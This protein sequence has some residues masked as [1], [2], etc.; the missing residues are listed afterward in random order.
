MKDKFI[1]V[2]VTDEDGNEAED[3]TLSK[4]GVDASFDVDLVDDYGLQDDGTGI[5]GDK[6]TVVYGATFGV[7]TNVSWYKD[8]KVVATNTVG[9]TVN[10]GLTRT[11]S[12]SKWGTGVYK[13]TITNTDG[14]VATTNEIEIT[15]KEDAAEILDFT[16]ENDYTDGLDIHYATTDKRAVATVTMSK[17]YAGTFSV[18]RATDTAFKSALAND[19]LKTS[20]AEP[21]DTAADAITYGID[22]YSV[23]TT[24]AATNYQVLNANSIGS[25]YGYI[26][27]DGTVTYKWVLDNTGVVRGAD[28]VVA[29]D[30]DSISSDKPGTGKANVSDSATAPYVEAPASIAVTKVAENVKPEITFFDEDDEVL[31]WFGYEEDSTSS[32]EP[33]GIAPS[34]KT[35]LATV[36]ASAAKVYAATN[37]TTDPDGDGVTQLLSGTTD[38]VAKGVWTVQKAAGDEAYF[39]ATVKF[40]K[41]IFGE[42]ALE[43]K[44]EAAP[45]AQ[46]AATDMSLL[47]SKD[48][49]SSAVVS[50]ANLRADGTVYIARGRFLGNGTA[51]APE[52]TRVV[53]YADIMKEFNPDD[54][55]TFVAKADVEAGAKS[56]TVEN[57][58][59]SFT[60]A[61]ATSIP[62]ATKYYVDEK[63]LDSVYASGTTYG[64]DDY[65]A[66]FVPDDTDN[67][68]QVSTNDTFSKDAYTLNA[69]NKEF[70]SL[71]VTQVPKTLSND[72]KVPG[73]I[74]G[75][76]A[77]KLLTIT[78]PKL[79]A[80]DQFGNAILRGRAAEDVDSVTAVDN[81]LTTHEAGSAKYAI[82]DG[83]QVTIYLVV[84]GDTDSKDGYTI[85]LLGSTVTVINTHTAKHD[86]TGTVATGLEVKVDGNT[87]VAGVESAMGTAS[88]SF[89]K[90]TGKPDA[91]A[92]VATFTGSFAAGAAATMQ[93]S[94][95]GYTWDDIATDAD[96]AIGASAI[97]EDNTVSGT[98]YKANTFYRIKIEA[99]GC[100][101]AYV[102]MDEQ[103]TD[104]AVLTSLTTASPTV[105]TIVSGD[106]KTAGSIGALDQFGNAF[107][108]TAVDTTA[109]SGSGNANCTGT[110][111]IA[112]T[113][114]ATFTLTDGT[115][116]NGTGKV[117]TYV[118]AANGLTWTLT[119]PALTNSAVAG[120]WTLTVTIG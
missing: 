21:A 17:N 38:P 32:R 107:L 42:S 74:T 114:V 83:G 57:A 12:A 103:K 71:R 28:Y 97:S 25:G 99:A 86:S 94:A 26:N 111:S 18:Y 69:T 48:T 23:L 36:G 106:P 47:E 60:N 118:D 120:T 82:A 3:E 6:L 65:V 113:G 79:I 85:S 98:G 22:R 8:G 76:A 117:F 59:G 14:E 29:F 90:L 19:Y 104:A 96:L 46:P 81:T 105:Q 43:L 62:T 87:L 119:S 50:F 84:E 63:P 61:N 13:V 20:T 45:T 112:D 72:K 91:A 7:P 66:I 53:A 78:G 88:V 110:I 89:P 41:G 64:T 37:K 52:A 24:N 33:N 15:D 95:D 2:V 102:Y 93:S 51:T 109:L 9:D 100:A 10:Q 70:N 44:S 16:L 68:G 27:P 31:G 80:K 58:I 67:Y 116:T 11:I 55:T 34:S 4:V 30:Q 54:A 1:K 73:S 35:T 77:S 5:I 92:N 101:D 49:S 39:F 75:T 40:N 56:V 115:D 108:L